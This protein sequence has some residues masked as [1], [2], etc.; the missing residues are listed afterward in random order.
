M[1]ASA[2]LAG[3]LYA[4]G[5][6]EV[7]IASVDTLFANNSAGGSGG[8]NNV[9]ASADKSLFKFALVVDAA[10]TFGCGEVVRSDVYDFFCT[11]KCLKEASCSG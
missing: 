4:A 6:S 3:A 10:S 5:G 9:E 2:R 11:R 7:E 8:N 1:I